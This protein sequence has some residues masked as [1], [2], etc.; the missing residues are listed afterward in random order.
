VTLDAEVIVVGGGPAGSATAWALASQGIS[1][2]IV[3]RARFPRDKVCSEYLSPQAARILSAMDVLSAI[4]SAASAR[5]TGMQ[6][7]S[8]SGHI[9]RASFVGTH[10]FRGFSDTGIAIRRTLLDE[11]LLRRAQAAGAVV[12]EGLKVTDVERSASGRVDGVCVSSAEGEKRTLR[13]G[14]IVGADGL[15]SVIARRLGLVSVRS[16]PRRLA[17]VA[18]YSGVSDVGQVGEMYVER[19]GYWGLANVGGGVTN[20]AVV[21]PASRGADVAGDRTAFFEEWIQSHPH[22]TSRFRNATRVT[23]VRATGPFASTARVAWTPGAAL[24]GDAADFFDPFTGEGIYAALRGGE[25]I[26]PFI[27]DAVRNPSGEISDLKAYERARRAEFGG[28]WKFERL[29]G[30]AV[31]SPA[32]MNRVA[33]VLSR[34][35]EMADLMVGVAGDFIPASEVLSP[36]FLLKFLFPTTASA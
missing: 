3:D 34:R 33:K 32:V 14:M 26:A 36:R 22:M 35:R 20:V 13:A 27:A 11:I 15:R 19:G 2:M 18:H 6:V 7:R 30:R 31:S 9:V 17:L 23:S 8:P 1:T 25:L 10:G 5:L 12:R 24:V 29:I 4:D 16:W 21:V 28:K